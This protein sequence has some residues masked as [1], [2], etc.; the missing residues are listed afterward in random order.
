LDDETPSLTTGPDE[1]DPTAAP[2]HSPAS[3][4][5]ATRARTGWVAAIPCTVW[6]VTALWVA[7]LFGA[8][9]V[10]PMSYGADEPTHIDMAY[11]YSAHPFT[12]YAPG[13]LQYTVASV[14]IQVSLPGYPPRTRL[15]D[16]PILPRSRRPSFAQLGGHTFTHGGQPNQMVQHPP[17]YYW[18]EAVILRLP[19]VSGLAWDVQVWL[20][21]LLSIACM[22]PVP[23]LA[24]ATAK[25]LLAAPF[26][27]ASPATA[28]RLALLAA[29]LPLTVP[30]LVRDGGAVDN[31]SLLIL[32]VS[33]VLWG[34]ARV[35]TGDLTMR[36]GAVIAAALAVGLWTKGFALALPPV[37]LV[38]YL[39]PRAE[40]LRAHVT[41]AW[42]PFSLSVIGGLVGSFWW[43]RNL[44]DYHTI[45]TN[46]F[47]ASWTRN[48][49][50][51]VPDYKGTF[52]HFLP[53]FIDG[54]VMRIWGEVGIPDSPSPGPFIIYG[55]FF[56]ALIGVVAALV[57]RGRPGAR[58]RA[59]VLVAVPVIFFLL[60]LTGS[61][62]AFHKW[63]HDGVRSNQGRYI[64]G[65]VV[66]LSA[67]FAVGWFRLVRP[68]FHG[69]IAFLV[70][71]GAVVTN[72]ATWLLILRSWYQPA[73]NSG[74]GSGTREAV[75]ALLRWS[76]L[77]DGLTVLFVFV[78]PV[79]AAVGCLLVLGA[80]ARTWPGDDHEVGR[81][82]ASDVEAAPVLS[83]R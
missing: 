31:D 30:N 69:R 76:P 7:L 65:G 24:W 60:A 71:V 22:S 9:L 29:A 2:S 45:Q 28:S 79:V 27:T 20:M 33:V 4:A 26:G 12:F 78:L 48:H 53:P 81:P 52:P 6:A 35:V 72:A 32:A 47:G 61:Y 59:G 57:T 58:R 50:Y 77:P 56:V 18:L 67:L 75:A 40:G 8:S 16:A 80:D 38:A 17:L 74:Y 36:T 42:R 3:A 41:R 54:F 51:G 39:L 43:V 62:G 5:P 73:N 11:D 66:A 82:A 19:G 44:V 55:W 49:I 64:Y 14:R 15:A 1:Q 63:A 13:Q 21:R 46:G 34:V 70:A 68:R 25:R 83:S 10:W 23:L 37:I